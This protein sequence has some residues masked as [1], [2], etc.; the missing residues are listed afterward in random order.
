MAKNQD[1]GL[2]VREQRLHRRF[3]HE[4]TLTEVVASRLGLE[5][6]TLVSEHLSTNWDQDLTR[7]FIQISG[8]DPEQSQ[9]VY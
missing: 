8:W 2:F 3:R 5:I 1:K 7:G 9:L 6:P 4:G